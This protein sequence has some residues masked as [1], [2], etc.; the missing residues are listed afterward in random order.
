M[1]GGGSAARCGL[2]TDWGRVYAA[3]GYGVWLTL[4][5]FA[6]T[7]LLGA[8]LLLISRDESSSKGLSS[9]AAAAGGVPLAAGGALLLRLLVL[10]AWWDDIASFACAEVRHEVS[11]VW[12]LTRSSLDFVEA[13]SA[14]CM[15]E[16]LAG[17]P[18]LRSASA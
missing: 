13:L 1:A 4:Q 12:P 10:S 11:A 6:W 5:S 17:R 9:R 2:A 18:T 15:L 16:L 3:P 14:V 7:A 8:A